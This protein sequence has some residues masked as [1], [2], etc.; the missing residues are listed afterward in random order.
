MNKEIIVIGGNHHNTLGV[1]RSLGEK[2]LKS[3]LIVVSDDP[4]PYIGYSKYIKDIR[5]VKSESEISTAM[6]SLH[7]SVEKAI[8]IACAD[9]ISSYLDNNR[10]ILSTDFVLPGSEQEEQITLLMNKNTMMQVAV[11]SGISAPKSWIIYPSKPDIESVT[12]PC[13][14]KPLVSKNGS[15]A[16][17]AICEK[18]CELMDYLNQSN[19]EELQIQEY[20]TKDIEF[21]LIGCSLD[22]GKNVII[23]GAS[24]ILRQPKNTNTG[25]LR[26]VP[27]SSFEYD[28][29]ACVEFIKR[30]GYSG[31]FSIEFIR[32]KNGTDYFMEINFRNDG[33]AICV[34]ASGMN[35]PYIWYLSNSEQSIE[36]ELCFD[37]MKEV[38]VMPEFQ[39]ISNAIHRRISWREWIK[40]VLKTDR[41]MEYSKYDQKP[42]WMYIIKRLF[43][44]K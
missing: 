14:V 30:T 13:I 20:I 37:S 21:Q 33:N 1:L 23:P 40:D 25:F 9:S 16:D 10:N 27:I 38:L 5:I 22:G 36:R 34:T 26:Y 12:F 2:G 29:T 19:C 17:I 18:R 35:L 8:V 15:K 4:K 43:N 42:F 11:E 41:F 44:S 6:Y 28:R 3:L 31:L 24:I 7:N 32:D 39:D